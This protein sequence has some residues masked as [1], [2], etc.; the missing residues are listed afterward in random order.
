MVLN[1][2]ESSTGLGDYDGPDCQSP[3]MKIIRLNQQI[4][5]EIHIKKKKNQVF[6]SEFLRSSLVMK[7]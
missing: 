5:K 6:G 1:S 4:D 7:I 3:L 2:L